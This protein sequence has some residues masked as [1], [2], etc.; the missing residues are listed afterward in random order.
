MQDIPI[1]PAVRPRL[2][3][4]MA[5]PDDETFGP[6]GTLAFY[7]WCGAAT[8]VVC[9]TDGAAGIMAPH[10]LERYGSAV[11]CREAELRC[12]AAKLGLHELHMLRYRDSGMP[13]TPDN[14][15]PQALVQA[16]LDE[17]TER[18]TR[19]IRAFRP[20]VVVT[21]DPI[22]G[23]R[24]PDHIAT[25]RATVEAFH[26]AGDPARYPGDLPPYQPQKLYYTIFPRFWLRLFVKLMPLFGQDPTRFG[27]N[28]DV[29]LTQL[30]DEEFPVHAQVDYLPVAAVREAAIACH[31]SQ[32]SNPTLMQS[33]LS[34]VMRVF[35]RGDSYM[36]AYP[37]P[38]PGLRERDLFAGV[39]I[40]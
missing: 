8:A 32:V 16:P 13:G 37:T 24:H 35:E 2:L 10:L 14:D 7:A 19:Q 20:H 22:G 40:D 27:Q 21:F 28:Q 17:V 29:D 23:Y 18:I 3:A 15:H 9:T 26:A 39:T 6:G 38:E 25:H 30:V 34:N 31:A 33:M 36:R 11:A 4:V 5:H 12:A 1:T